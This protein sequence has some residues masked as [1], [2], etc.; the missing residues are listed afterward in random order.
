MTINVFNLLILVGAVHGLFLS[1][2]LLATRKANKTSRVLLAMV[3]IFYTL[4]V[5]RVT[6]FDMGLAMAYQWPFFYIELLYGLGPSLYLYVRTLTQAQARFKAVDLLH[7]IPVL[8]ELI[9]YYSP[10][11]LNDNEYLIVKPQNAYDVLWL[12]QQFGAIFSV[13]IYIGLS[14]K[15]LLA[16]ASWVKDHYSDTHQKNLDWLQKPVMLYSLFFMLWFSLRAYDVIFYADQMDMTMYYPLL[17]LL[18]CT[19][20]WIGTKGYLWTQMVSKEPHVSVEPK[21]PLVT[22]Q[23]QDQVVFNRLKEYMLSAKPYLTNDLSLSDLAEQV[24]A[25][26]RTLSRVINQQAGMNFYDYI[27]QYRLQEFK[28]RLSI[29]PKH[30]ILDLAYVCGFN[31]KS[32]F[33]H[34]FKK[35]TG[36]TPSEFK[37]NLSD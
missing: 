17:L 7:Y 24:A 5:L 19:T 23:Q 20:Y 16:Y 33:N 28:H 1:G 22:D 30:R 37:K 32:T 15:I 4:P 25:K 35:H 21:Q 9:Y 27:N 26:P 13:L 6:L 36:V 10:W 14:I 2:L 29:E 8:L 3:L 11:Y 18:S 31:S 34:L 12:V